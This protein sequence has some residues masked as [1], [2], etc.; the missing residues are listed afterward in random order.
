MA[1]KFRFWP[2]FISP[3]SARILA[4]MLFP[5]A[6]FFIGLFSIDQYRSVLVQAEFEA[7]ERQGRILAR[8]LALEDTRERPFGLRGL[9]PQT[10]RHLLP[11]VG[12]GT[13]LRARVFQPSGQ[14]M[15]DTNKRG[16]TR[17]RI[18]VKR[19]MPEPVQEQVRYEIVQ[20]MNGFADLISNRTAV[21][22]MNMRGL[23][24][25]DGFPDVK[26]ALAGEVMRSMWRNPRGQLV[27]SVSL[28]IQDLRIVKGALLMT[29]TGGTIESEI[30]NVQWAFV[31][32]FAGI[33]FVTIL[34]GLYLA[35]S[36]TR[37]IVF[38]AASA[39]RLR[40]RTAEWCT[41]PV[42]YTQSDAADDT[43]NV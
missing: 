19:R 39:D 29:S 4:I 14:I 7:L 34:L 38:L 43:T 18:R 28:P 12:Y 10:M 24:H 22:V 41:R 8:S 20:M 1:E 36:I 5:L 42:S 31:Q 17:S 21:P 3:L 11:L 33:L 6:L 37:P 9:A 30:E 25:A 40:Q 23:R 27:L 26:R 13:Q 16:A 32:L 2:S 35:R 15:A